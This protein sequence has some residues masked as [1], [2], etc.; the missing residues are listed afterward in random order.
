MINYIDSPEL[1]QKLIN[2]IMDPLSKV[3]IQ[4][5]Q[6]KEYITQIQLLNLFRTIFFS[7]SF[8]KKGKLEEV[9][10]FFKNTFTK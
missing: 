8:R 10:N 7:S 4:A 1:C 9:R 2:Y 6:N 5:I 3:L